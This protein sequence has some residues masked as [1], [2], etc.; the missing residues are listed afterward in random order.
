MIPIKITTLEE[1]Q[2]VLKSVSLG[3]TGLLENTV[4]DVPEEQRIFLSNIQE[5][6]NNYYLFTRDHNIKPNIRINANTI[7]VAFKAL[8]LAANAINPESTAGTNQPHILNNAQLRAL[9]A[10]LLIQREIAIE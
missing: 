8:K 4:V 10:A 9:E 7:R 2:D 3:I 5:E 1:L 6:C